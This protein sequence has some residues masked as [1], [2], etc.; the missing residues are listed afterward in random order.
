MKWLIYN[1]RV[2]FAWYALA[3]F[4]SSLITVDHSNWFAIWYQ[5]KKLDTIDL[6]YFPK[7]LLSDLTFIN[8]SKG[9]GT[10]ILLVNSSAYQ[11][12]CCH[13]RGQYDESFSRYNKKQFQWQLMVP[14]Q[15]QILLP[16]MY[17][18]KNVSHSL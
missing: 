16:N 17:K 8:V 7:E 2:I 6:F 3:C 18:E 13:I 9:Q 10:D 1:M 15:K 11:S 5:I 14:P 4:C 12:L